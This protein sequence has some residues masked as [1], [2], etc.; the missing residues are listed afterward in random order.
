M[1][2]FYLYQKGQNKGW[3][4]K[5]AAGLEEALNW[6]SYKLVC[7][8]PSSPGT[9]SAR[10]S[11][12]K[13]YPTID[14][15]NETTVVEDI[16]QKVYADKSGSISSTGLKEQDWVDKV[17]SQRLQML[18]H[19][20]VAPETSGADVNSVQKKVIDSIKKQDLTPEDILYKAPLREARYFADDENGLFEGENFSNFLKMV[21]AQFY[22]L[23]F[24]VQ[25]IVQWSDVVDKGPDLLPTK[26]QL[27]E[28]FDAFIADMNEDS[29]DKIFEE[30]LTMPNIYL[31][32]ENKSNSRS[33]VFGPFVYDDSKPLDL[34]IRLVDKG[35]T[36]DVKLVAS[37]H[38]TDK[39]P[40]PPEDD[41][42]A[43]DSARKRANPTGDASEP[44][45]S[46]NK[47]AKVPAYTEKDRSALLQ[48]IN[49][50]MT[51]SSLRF[52]TTRKS[53]L[54]VD[55]DE[56]S[57]GGEDGEESTY[58]FESEAEALV[59]RLEADDA[60][61]ND[62][63]L[64]EQIGLYI[65]DAKL[66][67][68]TVTPNL[69]SLASEIQ[70]AKK[71]EFDNEVASEEGVTKQD[72]FINEFIVKLKSKVNMVKNKLK[73]VKQGTIRKMD[74]QLNEQKSALK[75]STTDLKSAE[76]KLTLLTQKLSS[77]KDGNQ[78]L[79]TELQEK[80][81]ALGEYIANQKTFDRLVNK[82]V[83]KEKRGESFENK[84]NKVVGDYIT[85][86]QEFKVLQRKFNTANER[87][88]KAT[89][90][91]KDVRLDKTALKREV[92]NLKRQV[93]KAKTNAENA[94]K[95]Q[96]KLVG[97]KTET[98]KELRAE[99]QKLKKDNKTLRATNKR[100][101]RTISS[102]DKT[103]TDLQAKR[104]KLGTENRE[105]SK[106]L[107][108]A[109]KNV[110]RLERIVDTTAVEVP[111][112]AIL[113]HEI[114]D[115]LNNTTEND[116]LLVVAGGQGD[117]R[118]PFENAKNIGFS[119]FSE[120]RRVALVRSDSEGSPESVSFFDPST[121]RVAYTCSK[122][123][124]GQLSVTPFL[125]EKIRKSIVGDQSII[126]DRV[127]LNPILSLVLGV[128]VYAG[129]DYAFFTN[130]SWN[131]VYVPFVKAIDVGS[132]IAAGYGTN[133]KLTT[134]FYEDFKKFA[135]AKL[136]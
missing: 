61:I 50:I 114:K 58:L 42:E 131:N 52:N 12:L 53:T 29:E 93:A 45:R 96:N 36:W 88:V 82:G 105:K 81:D 118:D 78:A 55:T 41:F 16:V 10:K 123:D 2:L 76:K 70:K 37:K 8:D 89:S 11:N 46:G 83:P 95:A 86:K 30:T 134:D 79:Q 63:T 51:N 69:R 102:Q 106:R 94:L 43:Q 1:S 116:I 109:Q 9:Y 84:L 90:T 132:G 25:P 39:L 62:N 33:F 14:K 18:S 108:T 35:E 19:Q 49:T 87:L 115:G 67:I 13:S 91:T 113:F 32:V 121:G 74:R 127:N 40:S 99:L 5:S 107:E 60:L 77:A 24:Q 130:Q 23:E 129:L 44:K 22:V 54:V 15:D 4:R 65:D 101:A 71:W 135:F 98:I 26:T 112:V 75:I 72:A 119:L 92:A 17:W 48:E 80:I 27:A 97:K 68:D 47:K 34:V 21:I 59:E 111:P 126:T 28:M 124:A 64:E 136:Q 103:I 85:K 66:L 122:D 120:K 56:E 38:N 3:N 57:V 100:Q 7:P 133:R 73:T 31:N 128:G 20:V 117:F 110:E 104:Q 6:I 125:T